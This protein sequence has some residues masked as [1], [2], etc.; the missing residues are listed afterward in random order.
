MDPHFFGRSERQLFGIYHS[1]RGKERQHGIVLCPP[2]PQEYM[3]SHM[4]YRKLA[5]LLAR[6]G[7]HVLRFD[8]Y[9]TGDSAGESREGTLAEWRENLVAAV[10]D[11]EECS[12]VAKVSLLGFR[13]GAA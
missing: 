1:P 11:L 13:L 8:Y 5:G 3:W 2:A 6:D 4:A 12:G 7:F 9:G 10:K